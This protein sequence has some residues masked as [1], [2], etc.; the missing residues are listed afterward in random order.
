[1]AMTHY[2]PV[3]GEYWRLIESYHLDPEPIFR[4]VQ[5][6]PDLMNNIYARIPYAGIEALWQEMTHVIDD[7]AIGLKLADF[8]HPSSSGPL[9]YAWLASSSL[10]TAFERV[11][12]FLRVFTDGMSCRI[13]ENDETFEFI[14]SFHKNSLNIPCHAD[15]ILV[16]LTLLCRIN[17][18]TDLNPQS[19]KFT[20][21]AP[22][23][24]GDYYAYFRCP[25]EFDANTNRLA[26]TVE[27]V[28][29]RLVCSQPQLAE[30]NDQVMIKY[31]AN[32]DQNNIVE[33]VKAIIIEQLPSGK[34]NDR[35]VADSLYLTPRTLQRKLAAQGT[36][37]K[38]LLNDVRKSLADQ[39]IKDNHLSINEI[40]FLL[41][42]S[43]ISSFSRA[44]KRWNGAAPSNLRK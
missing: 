19:V 41:G 26:F 32:L 15:A 16:T 37:F 40:S 4:K 39:Y 33:K 21:S 7:P 42:F 6:D 38:T 1:M 11:I 44:F 12:R 29:K 8:W 36:S 10:R 9:G 24:T 17:Y 43:E 22:V 3:L 30:L 2:A 20:H 27:T 14:H 5:L 13:E 23:N 18:G 25:V 35:Y 34:I 31:L 28:D